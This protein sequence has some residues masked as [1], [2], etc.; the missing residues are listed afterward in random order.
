M[1]QQGRTIAF[2]LQHQ[3]EDWPTNNDSYNFGAAN[4]QG[5]SV[6]AMKHPDKTIELEILGPLGQHF[7]FK[8][9]IPQCDESGLS[10]VI[11]WNKSNLKLF[12]N[13]K[14]TGKGKWRTTS[15]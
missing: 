15:D 14:L 4:F 6:V 2:R 7:V 3:H 11:I 10:V 13:G 12:L 5:I 1:A 9:P 8:E